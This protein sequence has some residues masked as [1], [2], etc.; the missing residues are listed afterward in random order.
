MS[1]LSNLSALLE[2]AEIRIALGDKQ[3]AIEDL[4]AA[5]K[6]IKADKAS[7]RDWSPR[8]NWR[9]NPKRPNGSRSRPD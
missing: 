3:R 9:V 2:R 4:N 7:P 1:I 6:L 8:M 5:E